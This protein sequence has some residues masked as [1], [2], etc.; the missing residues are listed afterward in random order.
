MDGFY[1]IFFMQCILLA[2]I[3]KLLRKA[4]LPTSWQQLPQPISSLFPQKHCSTLIKFYRLSSSQISDYPMPYNSYSHPVTAILIPTTLFSCCPCHY[5]ANR[6]VRTL[7][8]PLTPTAS[9]C[10]QLLYYYAG[11]AI[12][13]STAPFRLWVN[14]NR[15]M[16]HLFPAAQFYHKL[17]HYVDRCYAIFLTTQFCH[18]LIHSLPAAMFHHIFLCVNIGHSVP[19][20]VALFRHWPK[21]SLVGYLIPFHYVPLHHWLLHSAG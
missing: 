5:S 7:A 6:T 9:F 12:L 2:S 8:D 21:C 10:H 13:S 19:F 3:F 15:W 4:H 17:I 18:W 11:Q 20:W 16:L 14:H 1:F